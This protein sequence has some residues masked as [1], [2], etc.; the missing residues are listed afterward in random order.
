MSEQKQSHEVEEIVHR[1]PR[2]DCVEAQMWGRVPKHFCIIEGSQEHSGLASFLNGRSLEPPR[3]SLELPPVQTEQSGEK[4]LGQGGDTGF[5]GHSD[6][7]HG[8]TFQKDHHLCSTLPIRPYSRVARRK[9]LLSKKHNSPFG[10]C[11]KTAKG[12]RP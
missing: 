9:P 5:G 3:L 11:Q 4:D 2:Q 8:R 12:L 10:V 7:G 6:R 1:A